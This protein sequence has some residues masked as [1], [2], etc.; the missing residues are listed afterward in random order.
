MALANHRIKLFSNAKDLETFV[1]TAAAAA[2]LVGGAQAFGFTFGSVGETLVIEG[3]SDGGHDFSTFRRTFAVGAAGPHADI[4]ALLA[5]LNTAARWDGASLPTE[6]VISNS[7][8]QV[9]ITH[10]LTGDGYA[11]RIGGGSSAIGPAD[12]EDLLF[13]PGSKAAGNKGSSGL[14]TVVD[15]LSD[16]NGSLVLVYTV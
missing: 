9:I 16:D 6:F 3:S 2:A 5:E 11:L 7:G 1:N 8:N 13:G 12:D 10:A 14:L 15:V 4:A